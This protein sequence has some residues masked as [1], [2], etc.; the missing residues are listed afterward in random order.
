MPS[1]DTPAPIAEAARRGYVVA[2][3]RRGGIDSG[4]RIAGARRAV[5]FGVEQIY[6]LRATTLRF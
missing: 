1:H 3:L 4:P 5:Q 6:S 2:V